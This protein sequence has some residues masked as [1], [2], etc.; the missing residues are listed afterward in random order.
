VSTG[1][2]SY[3]TATG[4]VIWEMELP[5]GTTAGPM[6]YL[7]TGKQYIVVSVSARDHSHEYQLTPLASFVARC[8]WRMSAP[9]R[10]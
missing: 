10:W 1:R 4:S 3:D 8:P 5:S 6:T 7:L 9:R 2:P